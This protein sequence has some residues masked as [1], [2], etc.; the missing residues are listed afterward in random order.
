[1]LWQWRQIVLNIRNGL[2]GRVMTFSCQIFSIWGTF[3][4]A[5][6]NDPEISSADSAEQDYQ[7]FHG[8]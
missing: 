2:V 8:I 4:P 3:I 5:G 1:M 7:S 6:K